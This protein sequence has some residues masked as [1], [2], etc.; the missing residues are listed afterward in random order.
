[1]GTGTHRASTPEEKVEMLGSDVVSSYSVIDHDCEDE[2]I[3]LGMTTIKNYDEYTFNH[4]VN[5]SIYSLAIGKRLGFSK[6]TLTELGITALL[7]DIGKI[8]IKDEILQKPGVL[9]AGEYQYI[10]EHPLIGVKS[11]KELIFSKT[12]S[13]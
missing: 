8:G 1:V 5:V 4:S 7:H 12:R 13:R 3:L 2:S 9:N 6:K 11:W 10:Q